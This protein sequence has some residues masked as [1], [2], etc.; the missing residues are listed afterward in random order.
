MVSY[1]AQCVYR[2]ILVE[3]PIQNLLELRVNHAL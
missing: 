1:K 3:R 2:Y